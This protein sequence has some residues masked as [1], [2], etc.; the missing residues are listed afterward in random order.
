MRVASIRTSWRPEPGSQPSWTAKS[1]PQQV[2][3][4]EHRDRDPEQRADDRGRVDPAA[5]LAGG[6]VAER[7][8][9]PDREDHRADGQLDGAREPLEELRGDRP[10]GPGATCRSPAGSRGPGSAGTARR[11]AGRGRTARCS[12]AMSSGVA[13]SPSAAWA[14][15][16]GRERSQAKSRTDS[17]SRIGISWRSRRT[18][19]RSTRSGHLSGAGYGR[20]R[21]R[22]RVPPAR[23]GE[24]DQSLR[25]TVEK[26]SAVSGL[27]S[28]P[29]TLSETTSAGGECEIGTPGR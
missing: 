14:G 16:P 23:P 2:G 11:S 13:R 28:R 12:G 26:T 20:S 5:V 9:D 7:D 24:P 19:K 10:A 8:A 25:D 15:P 27:G 6:E 4:E 18:M 17:P 29:C 3:E 1:T 22:Q 21:R